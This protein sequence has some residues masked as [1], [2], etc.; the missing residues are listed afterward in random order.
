[1]LHHVIS[2]M[3]SDLAKEVSTHLIWDD[4][5]S[6]AQHWNILSGDQFACICACQCSLPGF[7]VPVFCAVL[8]DTAWLAEQSPLVH[9]VGHLS[10]GTVMIQLNK[11]IAVI[12][13]IC[14]LGKRHLTWEDKRVW[15][16]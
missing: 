2:T 3:T 7:V 6:L 11:D 10:G 15:G 8:C 14:S 13:G 12:V 4:L 5:F 1:M 16:S 9:W